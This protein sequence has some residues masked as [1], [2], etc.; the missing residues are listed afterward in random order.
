MGSEKVN[1]SGD[2]MGGERGKE[3]HALGTEKACRTFGADST[4][5]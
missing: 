1:M 3:T 4:M 2:E 5:R